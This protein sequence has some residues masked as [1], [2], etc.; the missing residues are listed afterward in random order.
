[1]PG[2]DLLEG[3]G[4]VGVPPEVGLVVLLRVDVGPHL[5]QHRFRPQ[6]HL[7]QKYSKNL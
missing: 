5:L 6:Q 4:V 1:M 7:I 3:D 2:A